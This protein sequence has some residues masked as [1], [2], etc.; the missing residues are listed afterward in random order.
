MTAR[1]E[2]DVLNM[3]IETCRDSARGFFFMNS[4]RN[5]SSPPV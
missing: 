3:L 1:T 4:R 5:A 2:R